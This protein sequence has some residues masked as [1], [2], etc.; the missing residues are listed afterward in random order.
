MSDYRI[1][2]EKHPEFQVEAKS[3]LGELNENLQLELKTL[4]LLNV[5]DLFGFTPDLLEKSRYSVFGE[6]VTDSVTD[7][8]DLDGAKYIAVEYLPGQFDQRAAS[9][10]DCVH[11]I[12]P[13]ARI[14]IKSSKLLIVDSDASEETL[15]KIRHYYI[16]PVESR[17]KDL[18]KLADTEHAAVKPVPVL[19]GFRNMSGDDLKA[20]CKKMGL[21]MNA[22]DLAEVVKYFTGEGRDPNETELRILDTYWSDHCRHTTFTTEL[23]SIDVED[24]FIKEDID[25]TMALY[26]RMRSETG[27]EKKGLNLMDMATIGAK[28]LRK[29]GLLD[30]LEVSEE[31]NACSI[32]I[33]V[34]VDGQTER[35]LLMFKNETHNHPTEI[36]PFGGAATC[37]GG[38]IRDPLSGR[39]YV[40]QAMRV[41]GA[42]DIYKPVSE[43]LPGK[44][45]QK[46]IT[47]KAAQGYSSYGNQIGLATTHV[48][49]IYHEGYTAKRMEVG[50]VVGAV[51]AGDVR[52]ESPKAGDVVLM[53]GGRTGRD[54]IGGATGSS[55]EHT[56]ESLETC[57]SEVQKGNAPEERKLERLFRRPEVTRLIKKSNDFG[58]G[59]VSV[60]IG[61]LADGLDIY[62]DR[63]PVKYSGMNS[64]ELAISESQERMAV[65]VEAKDEEEFKALCHSENIEVTHVA[66]VTDTARMRMFYGDKVVVDLTRAFIDS[67][68]AK[69][70]SKATIGAVED[71]D[72][73][74]R[75]VPGKNLKERMFANLQDPNVTCQKGLIEMFDSTIGRSTVLM[76]FGGE[77]Q[78]TET[79]VSVQKLPV[80]GY[81]DTAS[82]M[83]FGFNPDICDWSPYHGA[84]YSFI[85]ACSKVVAAGGHWETM[86]FSCQEYFE[87]MTADPKVWGKPT[88]ALLGA[89]KMQKELGL[90]SIGGKDS[91]S[92]SF[93]TED[94]TIHVPPTLIAFGITPVKA[95]KV[96]S[97]ELKWEGDRLYLVK[98]TPLA[99]RMPDTE[100]L[101]RNWNNIQEKIEDGTIVAGWAVGFGGVAEA[102]CKMSFGNA[103]GFDVNLSEDE[104][105]N[106]SYGSIVVETDGS[107][108]DFENAVEIGTVTSGEDGNVRVNGTKL[109]IFEMMDFN[110]SLFEKVYP[111]VSK[112][113]FNRL[114]P[115]GMEGVKPF[116]AKKADLEYKGPKVDKVIAYLPVFPGT[117]CDYDSAKAFRKAGAEIRTSVFRNLSDKDVFESIAQM[118]KNIEDCQILMLS[119]GFSAGDE[120]DGSGKFIANVLNNKDIAEAIEGLL[121]RGGLILGICNGFQALVK[122]GLLPYGELGKVTKD[123]P[124]LFRNDINRHISQMVT[125][126]V[127]STNSPWLRGMAIGDEYTIPVS[128]GEGKFVVSEELARELF[129]NGQVAFQYVDPLTDEPTMES[130]YNPNGSYYAIEGIIS[131]NGQ[132]LGKMGHSERYERNLLKNIEADL[133]QPLFENAVRYFIG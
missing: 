113:D 126:R 37:L 71:R 67:A 75:D 14:S 120:P 61:E 84:A 92:G 60:A 118:K 35:W 66:E 18:S 48:R 33:D 88:A 104:L 52:R 55:K 129:A 43:T 54:G 1:F 102:L 7:S 119:G 101:K 133:E 63:V 72:P 125:T 110:A 12:D 122:S 86:R 9:A 6:I 127:A 99:D 123:S 34:D 97:P 105:F 57:G 112:P 85:E 49:E 45:P 38:A 16:N 130:P 8:I 26:L 96:I 114:L 59:G 24:S 111:A 22:D 90:A 79:Q 116:K 27:R 115:K 20:Y 62:L 2:V 121:S 100:Q 68:G 11:L 36:E 89:L 73:F 25:G 17:A 30:D 31:N 95:D 65:V 117:N 56:E 74:F 32:F 109:S 40:Y 87:R 50:A 70:Y 28:Y 94:G 108:L 39:S 53:I 128:H 81:T 19:E 103:F 29:N 47:R 5:Y 124:T 107:A 132:I 51:K 41:T 13:T 64:T 15:E 98:H 91:M 93:E 106:L 58:A 131:R 78:T 69:H 23:E 76:P 46:V 82:M 83:A 44:L 21:A 3:L 80:K 42:G 77:L 4:R 10:V